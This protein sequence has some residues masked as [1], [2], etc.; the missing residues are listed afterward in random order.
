M[1]AYEALTKAIIAGDRDAALA[2]AKAGR[3]S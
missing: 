2:L 1:P 3:S